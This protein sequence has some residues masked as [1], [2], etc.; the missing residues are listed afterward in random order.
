MLL[1]QSFKGVQ[2]IEAYVY[3]E[4]LTDGETSDLEVVVKLT[5]LSE[6]RDEKSEEC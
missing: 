3:E 2:K 5:P 6:L 4:R 1:E